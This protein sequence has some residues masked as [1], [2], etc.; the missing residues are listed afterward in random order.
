MDDRQHDDLHAPDVASSRSDDDAPVTHGTT[1]SAPAKKTVLVVEDDEA[2]SSLLVALLEDRGYDAV[3]ALDGQ[4]AIELARRLVPHLITLDLALPGSDGHEVL[5]SLKSD[6]RTR[7]IPVVV[8][9]AFAS[10][11]PGH[12]GLRCPPLARA[13]KSA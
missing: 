13:S 2:V 11:K 10:L 9:S 5:E 4:T 3:P 8:I 6:P 7:D 12:S 1:G